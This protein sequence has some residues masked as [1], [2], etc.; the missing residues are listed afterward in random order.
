LTSFKKF[1]FG[2]I[3]AKEDNKT[4][5]ATATARRASSTSPT[6]RQSGSNSPGAVRDH[7]EKIC[8]N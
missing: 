2:E 4:S 3:S 6:G 5:T 8:E 7:D 1:G